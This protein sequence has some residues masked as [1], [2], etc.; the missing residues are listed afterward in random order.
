LSSVTIKH[1]LAFVAMLSVVRINVI[2]LSDV[3]LNVVIASYIL[4]FKS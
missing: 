3:I 4:L 1:I 2:R